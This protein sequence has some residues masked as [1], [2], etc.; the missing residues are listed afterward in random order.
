VYG[1]PEALRD[2]CGFLDLEEAR[3]SRDKLAAVGLRS[4]IAI[5]AAPDS[6]PGGPVH[7]EFWL[8]VETTA[9]AKVMQELGFDETQE[10]DDPAPFTCDQCGKDVTEDDAKCPHCGARFDD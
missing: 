10:R 2:N 7:E 5:R 6:P 3:S 8:R 4:E 9:L 1:R